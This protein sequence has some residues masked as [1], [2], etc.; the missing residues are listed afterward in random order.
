MGMGIR[1][2]VRD[3]VGD[4]NTSMTYVLNHKCSFKMSDNFCIS[5]F[6][7]VSS[8]NLQEIYLYIK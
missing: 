2:G 3:P 5:S 7:S 1:C 4:S 8:F 6:Y